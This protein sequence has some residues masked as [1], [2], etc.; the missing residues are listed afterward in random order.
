MDGL[1]HNNKNTKYF[2]DN[3][4]VYI[5]RIKQSFKPMVPLT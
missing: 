5:F 2:V 1:N 4:C 3:L